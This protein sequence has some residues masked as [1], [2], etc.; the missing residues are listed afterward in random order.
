VAD[1]KG[2][3]VLEASGGLRPGRLREIAVLGVD[4]LSVGWLTH[5]APAADVA[6]EIRGG[7]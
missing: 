5:S 2:R 4:C 6:M 3:I 1:G 7:G